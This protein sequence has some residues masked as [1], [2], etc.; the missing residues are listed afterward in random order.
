M[1][2]LVVGANSYIAKAFIQKW[3]TRFSFKELSR[4]AAMTDYFDLT[5]EYFTEIDVV[6]NFAAIVHQKSPDAALAAKI[7]TELPLFM[8]TM[9]KQAGVKQFIQ[10]STI[11]VYGS[12]V[13]TIDSKSVVNPDTLYGKTKALA[14]TRLGKMSDNTFAVT[15]VRPPIVY[16][17]NAP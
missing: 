10:L 17:N 2:V 11:A 5:P 7:N 3:H 16:G 13:N 9:A 1:N 6:V 14:D 4:N 15:I 12:Y 8:A